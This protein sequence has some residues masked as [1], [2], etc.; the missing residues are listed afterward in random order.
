MNTDFC[1][2][3]NEPA[4]TVCD[5]TSLLNQLTMVPI[6]TSRFSNVKSSIFEEMIGA[7]GPPAS[8]VGDG[9]TGVDVTGTFVAVGTGLEVAS[10]T[11]AMGSSV[12]VGRAVGVP[13]LVTGALVGSGV[14]VGTGVVEGVGLGGIEITVSGT[15]EGATVGCCG[16]VEGAVPGPALEHATP[17]TISMAR[18]AAKACFGP[19]DNTFSVTSRNLLRGAKHRSIRLLGRSVPGSG[20]TSSR[21]A[22]VRP[23]SFARALNLIRSDH[24]FRIFQLDA[25]I[26]MSK[27]RDGIDRRSRGVIEP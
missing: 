26:G 11:V 13:V 6:L 1:G 3:S 24:P 5:T 15:G 25:D 21:K 14:E 16:G 22:D 7:S 23:D 4:V 18:A 9:G 17:M 20:R 10:S 2:S 12:A 19:D 27:N 8:G